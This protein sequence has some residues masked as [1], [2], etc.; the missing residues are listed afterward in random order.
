MFLIKD[1]HN[2]F[3]KRKNQFR[4]LSNLWKVSDVS[5]AKIYIAEPSICDLFR[6]K[7]QI[8]VEY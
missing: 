8:S 1:S 6:N 2:I 4:Q 3:D 5:R 7:F